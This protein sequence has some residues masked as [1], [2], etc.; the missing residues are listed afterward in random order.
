[1]SIIHRQT[2]NCFLGNTHGYVFSSKAEVQQKR[3]LARRDERTL[4]SWEPAGE[5]VPACVSHLA[6]QKTRPH[7]DALR[8]EQEGALLGSINMTLLGSGIMLASAIASPWVACG[9]AV[10]AVTTYLFKDRLSEAQQDV[11]DIRPA[12]KEYSKRWEGFQGSLNLLEGIDFESKRH[13]TLALAR[14]IQTKHLTTEEVTTES[15]MNTPIASINDPR[16]DRLWTVIDKR[17]VL[18]KSVLDLNTLNQEYRAVA[19]QTPPNLKECKTITQTL[20]AIRSRPNG[21][22]CGN[23]SRRS[24]ADRMSVNKLSPTRLQRAWENRAQVALSLG[25]ASTLALSLGILPV[26]SSY[27]LGGITL[28]ALG[29]IYQST[30]RLKSS[31]RHGLST[32]DLALGRLLGPTIHAV[33]RAAASVI[34]RL[35]RS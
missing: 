13:T 32:L 28:L 11:L 2:P 25:G 10:T 12:Y 16:L 29:C 23:S 24:L 9:L 14:L 35:N 18:D 33:D 26:N 34:D 5:P 17:A 19:Q 7:M 8:M 3:E 30:D 21:N 20:R 6:I 31:L 1:M 27:A 4:Y 15:E 22:Q